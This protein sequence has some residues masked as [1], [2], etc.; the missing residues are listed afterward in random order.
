MLQLLQVKTSPEEALSE[1]A[2]SEGAQS[3]EA[4][5]EGAQSKEA[6]SYPNGKMSVRQLDKWFSRKVINEVRLDAVD[7]EEGTGRNY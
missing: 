1:E 2:P 4:L 6:P 3:E 7:G 5:S